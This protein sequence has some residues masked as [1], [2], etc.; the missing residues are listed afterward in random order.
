MSSL[1]EHLENVIS[2][3]LDAKASGLLG[4]FLELLLD[5]SWWILATSQA[6][7]RISNTMPLLGF[8]LVLDFLLDFQETFLLFISISLSVIQFSDS[9][10]NLAMGYWG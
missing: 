8:E 10:N 6:L 9:L 3:F 4:K 2:L 1:G 7:D 5:G